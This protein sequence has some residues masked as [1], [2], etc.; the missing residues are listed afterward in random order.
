MKVIT[1][2]YKAGSA[3]PDGCTTIDAEVMKHAVDEFNK[4]LEE[5]HNDGSHHYGMTEG[6]VTHTVEKLE[7]NN[8]SIDVILN[9]LDTPYGDRI[10]KLWESNAAHP[11]LEWIEYGDGKIDIKTISIIPN[12]CN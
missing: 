2:I 9:I 6:H 1:T 12:C 11:S 5:I 7:A 3:L 10:K 8:D 4:R